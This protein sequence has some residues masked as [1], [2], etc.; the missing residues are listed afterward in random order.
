VKKRQI[1]IIL[2]I[3]GGF[4]I[5]QYPKDLRYK[6]F[7]KFHDIYGGHQAFVTNNFGPSSSKRASKSSP[8]LVLQCIFVKKGYV[9][10]SILQKFGIKESMRVMTCYSNIPNKV[11]N[12]NN[13]LQPF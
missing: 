12:K 4:L 13:H 2:H 10:S 8:F 11:N 6:I 1:S 7:N 5:C 9:E 3:L